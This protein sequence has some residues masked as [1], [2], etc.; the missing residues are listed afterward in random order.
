MN[1]C[2]SYAACMKRKEILCV[3]DSLTRGGVGWSYLPFSRHRRT[4]VNAGRD[5][6]TVWGLGRRLARLLQRDGLTA[7]VVAIGT[8]DVLLPFLSTRPGWRLNMGIRSRLMHCRTR[9]DDFERDVRALISRIRAAGLSTIIVGLPVMEL[10]DF[11]DDACERRNRMLRN[12][13][14]ES[15]SPFVDAAAAMAAVGPAL[16][17]DRRFTWSWFPPARVLDAVIMQ[18]APPTKDWFATARKLHL[19]VDGVH[20]NSRA[21]KAIAR[22]VDDALDTTKPARQATHFILDDL[23]TSPANTATAL[24]DLRGKR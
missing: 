14:T 13:A 23:V 9:D 10:R 17:V 21:A 5:G 8:D 2:E 24:D 3:G 1:R 12:I 15:H 6:D 11:P 4:M 20:W 7:C 19:T 22:A 18:V 16:P